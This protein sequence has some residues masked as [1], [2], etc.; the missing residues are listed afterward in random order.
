MFINSYSIDAETQLE[1]LK[2]ILKAGRL[3]DKIHTPPV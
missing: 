1:E 3:R 2:M